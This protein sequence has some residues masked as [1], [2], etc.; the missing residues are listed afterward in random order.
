MYCSEASVHISLITRTLKCEVTDYN[1]LY[2]YV[3]CTELLYWYTILMC[4]I[5]SIAT[6]F[7]KSHVVIL[8][9][10]DPDS[11]NSE[12]TDENDRN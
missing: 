7:L 9:I 11:V 3:L 12:F 10:G 2:C 5:K 8:F 1:V 4:W 6:Q